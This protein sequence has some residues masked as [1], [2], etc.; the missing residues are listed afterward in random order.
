M[1]ETDKQT[2]SQTEKLREARNEEKLLSPTLSSERDRQTD[3][4]GE[5]HRMKG[6]KLYMQYTSAREKKCSKKERDRQIGGQR[7]TDVEEL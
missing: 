7:Q 5:R 4:D 6:K 3:L 1:R 2:D